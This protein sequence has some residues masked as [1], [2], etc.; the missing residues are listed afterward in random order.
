MSFGITPDGPE[1]GHT[2]GNGNK[3]DNGDGY[4]TDGLGDLK[5]TI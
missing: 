2:G 3:N 1:S 5:D 4:E